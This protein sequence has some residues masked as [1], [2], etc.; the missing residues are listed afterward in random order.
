MTNAAIFSNVASK[1]HHNLSSDSSSDSQ[2]QLETLKLLA[3][4]E[5]LPLMLERR[6]NI[7]ITEA[8]MLLRAL[9]VLSPFKS[10]SMPNKIMK[11]MLPKLPRAQHMELYSLLDITLELNLSHPSI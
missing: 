4:E 8:S 6:S 9:N 7:S 11:D 3:Q 5:I 10:P 1:Y 2:S